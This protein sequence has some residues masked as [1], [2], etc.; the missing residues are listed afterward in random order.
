MILR[1]DELSYDEQLAGRIGGKGAGLVRLME[2]GLPVPAAV[3]LPVEARGVLTDADQIVEQIGEPMA[4]R[5]SAVGEDA[6][7]RSA[8]G[9]YESVMGVTGQGLME[10]VAEVYRSAEL[11]RARAY[12]GVVPAAM[13]VVIQREIRPS[14]AGVAFSRD[15]VG[16]RD[17]VVIECVFGHGEGLVSGTRQPDRYR[18]A[19]EGRVQAD[20]AV[21]EEPYR[22][23]RSLRDD[24]ALAVAALARRA[25]QGF[26]APVDIEFCFEGLK[27]WLVQCRAITTLT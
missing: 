18:I 8:A 9:Q 10:A 4:V 3:V 15:P 21:K 11:E 13:A 24:E 5:S 17:A 27:L 6:R 22:L 19:G 2:L 7:D 25:E 14:R 23:L 26:G 20:L 1:V 12:R 16:E